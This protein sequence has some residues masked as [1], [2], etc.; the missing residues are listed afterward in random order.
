[1]S[2]PGRARSTRLLPQPPSDRAGRGAERV[3]QLT[4]PQP[5]L[6]PSMVASSS[7]QTQS[8]PLL[9]LTS[10]RCP[11]MPVIFLDIGFH[12]PETLAFRDRWR[13]T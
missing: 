7:F 6:G 10:L 2:G 5:T 1:M 8:L 11:D 3:C 4:K 9:H 12:L 13:A